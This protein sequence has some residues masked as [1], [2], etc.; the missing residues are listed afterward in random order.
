MVNEEQWSE[1]YTKDTEYKDK[2]G[3]TVTIPEGFKIS[4]ADTMNTVKKGLVV[5]DENDNEWVWIE[6]PEDVFIKQLIMI[7][8]MKK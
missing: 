2:N 8:I 1:A 5:K 4:M 6:V 7:Q 3:D